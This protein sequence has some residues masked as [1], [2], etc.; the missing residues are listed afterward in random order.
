[1]ARRANVV[2]AAP[3]E[4]FAMTLLMSVEL[5]QM[6]PLPDEA[7][8]ERIVAGDAA[9]FELLMRR[10]NQRLFRIARAVVRDDDEAEDVVQ[11]TYVRAY[12]H[13]D[14]FEGR[15]S[16]ATW[17]S[18]IAFHEALRRRRRQRR[19]RALGELDPE[20][21]QAADTTHPPDDQA[22][23]AETRAALTAALDALP[24]GLRAIVMLRLV[25]GL[26]TRETA[27]SLRLSESNVKVSLHRA[28]RILINAMER[29]ALTELRTQFSFDGERCDRIVAGVFDRL[30]MG[31]A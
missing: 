20:S 21:Q 14:R 4:R 10:H 19:N 31:G 13:L 11:E 5:Q 25:E 9:V 30:G 26:S 7:L 8:V 29:D 3:Q 18:R 27:E 12:T 2:R 28:R 1:M 16:V 23:R 17:L 22:T 24:T 15:S 6:A